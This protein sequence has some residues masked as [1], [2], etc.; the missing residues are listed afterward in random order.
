[1]AIK[2]LSETDKE[3]M[4]EINITPFTDV[5]LVLLIIFMIAA[6]AIIQNGFNINLPKNVAPTAIN[7]NDTNIVVSIGKDNQ[8]HVG[9]SMV[10]QS[11]L[12]AFL[13]RLKE[14]K[15]TD[16]VIVVADPEVKYSDVIAI[17]DAAKAAGLN[18]IALARQEAQASPTP[19]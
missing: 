7:E 10:A 5:L 3:L 4:A 16:K 8:I 13:T 6:T 11:D 18:S 15:N 17:M 19:H 2:V 14:N 9:S 1:M 12:A